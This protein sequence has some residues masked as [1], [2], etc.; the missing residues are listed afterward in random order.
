MLLL[1]DEP[2]LRDNLRGCVSMQDQGQNAGSLCW[3]SRGRG[4]GDSGVWEGVLGGAWPTGVP[5]PRSEKLW[6]EW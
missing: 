3:D 6:K 1:C 4:M 2:S 5:G